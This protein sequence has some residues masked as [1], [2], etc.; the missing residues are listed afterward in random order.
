MPAGSTPEVPDTPGAGAGAG[1]PGRTLG[2]E[3]A[4]SREAA[5]HTPAAGSAVQEVAAA[6][7]APTPG[8]EAAELGPTP[9][10]AGLAGPKLAASV[11]VAV[12]RPVPGEVVG[13]R[14]AVSARVGWG[15]RPRGA[16]RDRPQ[17]PEGPPAQ[18]SHRRR[19]ADRSGRQWRPRRRAG[20]H[21]FLGPPR[22]PMVWSRT[23]RAP[24]VRLRAG[25]PTLVRRRMLRAPQSA[26]P[27]ASG[28][29]R[30][31][32]RTSIPDRSR[33]R[34]LDTASSNPSGGW[35]ARAYAT[36]G[37]ALV[38]RS[39]APGSAYRARS[40]GSSRRPRSPPGSSW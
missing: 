21:Q 7:P 10:E 2:A 30:R 14:S 15:P 24:A 8:A 36:S 31:P 35:W 23:A 38:T 25:P 13:G 22:R 12:G 1:A 17:G 37:A 27:P 34:K 18:A 39:P 11:A 16:G 20:P 26:G 3:P 28:P 9:E 29:F 6:G 19:A 5:A 40:S 32:C 4:G 33:R